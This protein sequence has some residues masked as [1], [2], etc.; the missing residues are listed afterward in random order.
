MGLTTVEYVRSYS[1]THF[2]DEGSEA[3]KVRVTC[4]RLHSYQMARVKSH[5]K[6]PGA[7]PEPWASLGRDVNLCLLVPI[8]NLLP[9]GLAAITLAAEAE[10]VAS[11]DTAI[12]SE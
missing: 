6:Q 1:K 4:P 10:G 5:A 9:E 3:Q 11:V 8:P 2:T 7:M 12:N